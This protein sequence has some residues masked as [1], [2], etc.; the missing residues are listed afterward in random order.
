MS[1]AESF[2][3]TA[4]DVLMMSQNI[5]RLEKRIDGVADDL[6]GVDRRLMRIELMVDL[7]KEHQPRRRH[8]K[9]LS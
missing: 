3:S 5:T 1:F 4:R 2:L 7:A 9:E 6:K 8:P